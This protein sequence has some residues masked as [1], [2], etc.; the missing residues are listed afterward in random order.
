MLVSTESSA[1]YPVAIGPFLVHSSILFPKCF[2]PIDT[3]PGS[4]HAS[5]AIIDL[6]KLNPIWKEY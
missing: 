5:E 6:P 3:G 1:I 2:V 4:S